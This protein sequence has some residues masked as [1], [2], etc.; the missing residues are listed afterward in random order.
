M[1]LLAIYHL[2]CRVEIQLFNKD[3]YQHLD[4]YSEFFDSITIPPKP[5]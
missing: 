3:P 1:A 2:I 5:K 4:C